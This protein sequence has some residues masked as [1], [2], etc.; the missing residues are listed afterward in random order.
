MP[1]LD[2]AAPLQDQAAVDMLSHAILPT[3]P[4]AILSHERLEHPVI[5]NSP[6]HVRNQQY[7][8]RWEGRPHS[9]NGVVPYDAVWQSP[10]FEEYVSGSDLIGHIPAA[11]AMQRHV[12]QVQNLLAGSQVNSHVPA[13]NPEIQVQVLRDYFPMSAPQRPNIQA[14]S[15]AAEIPPVQLAVEA[16]PVAWPATEVPK[17]QGSDI[18]TPPQR[19]LRRSQRPSRQNSRYIDTD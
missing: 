5:R 19:E 6:M 12:Q 17:T 4:S 16:Q 8:V 18:S 14:V 11:Q 13:S 3:I 15:R 2:I 1:V 9:D 7:L 10:A